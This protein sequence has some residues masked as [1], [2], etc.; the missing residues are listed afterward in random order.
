MHEWKTAFIPTCGHYEYCVI[1]YGLSCTSSV[2]QSLINDVLRDMLGKYIIAYMDG[3]LIFS[4]LHETHIH[5]VCQV[6]QRLTQNQ[7]FVKGEKCAV[8]HFLPGLHY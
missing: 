7:L 3:I 6:L 5:H 8:H 1:P 2:F 4:P